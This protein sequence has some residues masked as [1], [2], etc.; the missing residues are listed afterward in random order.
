MRSGTC[1]MRLFMV[2]ATMRLGG[3]ILKFIGTRP[4][5]TER[6][7]LRKITP[8]DA[9]D[10]YNNWT[11]DR[12][13]TKYLTWKP[14]SSLDQTKTV[15]GFWVYEGNKD[16]S[17]RWCIELKES[18]QVIGDISVVELHKEQD[19]CEIGYCLA[20]PYWSRGIMTEALCA[21]RDY[22]LFK[23]EIKHIEARHQLG[24][25]ASGRVMEKS[26]MRYEGIEPKAGKD[27]E[28]VACDMAVYSI[29]TCDWKS[30]E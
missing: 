21:V 14:H 27:N 29:W 1:A 30:P 16:D 15:I 18:G 3:V 19:A 2:L 9:E 22:L 13:V 23:A 28:G 4:I 26:G 12:N 17:F 8:D 7:I 24:N 11:S 5:K 6:L 10:M 25:H 20:P